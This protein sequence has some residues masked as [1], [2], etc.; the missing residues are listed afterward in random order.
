MARNYIILFYYLHGCARSRNLS[1]VDPFYSYLLIL[2]ERKNIWSEL[3]S[4]PGPLATQATTLTTRP[5]LLGL[6]FGCYSSNTEKIRNRLLS[7]NLK[8]WFLGLP[9]KVWMWISSKSI[10]THL[11]SGHFWPIYSFLNKVLL[12]SLNIHQLTK[13]SLNQTGQPCW[14]A[15]WSFGVFVDSRLGLSCWRFWV[16][17]GGRPWS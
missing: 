2:K 16:T 7:P 6:V 8:F 15:F 11:K 4:N 12:P 10:S 13:A 9:V 17:S 14:L 5:W 3:E 1:C